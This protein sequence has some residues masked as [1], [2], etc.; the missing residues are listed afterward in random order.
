M[1]TDTT[2]ATT[3]TLKARTPRTHKNGGDAAQKLRQLMTETG[4]TSNG[5]LAEDMGVS[6]NTITNW[7]NGKTEPAKAVMMFLDLK[8]EVRRIGK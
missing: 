2:K 6:T 7:L 3:K 8:R 4:Y 1:R 5:Q